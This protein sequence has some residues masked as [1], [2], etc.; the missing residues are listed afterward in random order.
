MKIRKLTKH[1]YDLI[2]KSTF[3]ELCAFDLNR[4][5]SQQK[6]QVFNDVTLIILL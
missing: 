3:N 2:H 1:K 5:N 6:L 4:I